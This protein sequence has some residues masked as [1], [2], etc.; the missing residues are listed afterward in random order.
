MTSHFEDELGKVK[1]ALLTMGSYAESAV[2]QAVEAVTNR[3]D[4]LAEQVQNN[5]D[6]L[7]R[8]EKEIDDMAIILLAKAPLATDLRLVTVAM[9]ISQNLERVGDQATTIARR[10]VELNAEPQL[11]SPADV[12]RMATLA[13]GMLKDSL[14]AFVNRQADK[15][16][17]I[18][19]RDKE[20]DALNRQIYRELS[21][22][23]GENPAAISRCLNLMTVAKSLERVADHATN[24][25]QEVVYLCEALDIRHEANNPPP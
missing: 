16:R 1:K 4:R 18:I 7:D 17:A 9:K 24:I 3:N 25:A 11:K 10:A 13:L 22:L 23:M 12:P 5:D 8:Y 21:S 14:D 6:T 2:A 19:P 20:V 15:A